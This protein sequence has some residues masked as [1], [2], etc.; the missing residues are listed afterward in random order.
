M[1]EILDYVEDER[2]KEEVDES[3]PLHVYYCLCGQIVLIVDT[4]LTKLPVRPR[5]QATVIDATKHAH[6]IQ[7]ENADE[8]YLKWKDGIEHQFR[9]RCKKCKLLLF[10]RHKADDTLTLFVIKGSVL[11]ESDPS[12]TGNDSASGSAVA[13]GTTA[14]TKRSVYDQIDNNEAAKNRSSKI[15]VK[16]HV[17][18]KGKTGSVT[19]S[20]IEDE[21]DEI[22]QR[23]IADSYAANAKV[24]Y[25]MMESK[26]LLKRKMAEQAAIEDQHKKYK[27]TLI[28]NLFK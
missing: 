7:C 22:E 13:G 21:E 9:K 6:K 12:V 16:K 4:V 28:D 15:L 1:P 18:D 14:I 17:H 2:K 20:T 24:V 11:L 27:G 3:T 25:R 8:V 5:D 23:E 10:Y 26:G 19:V